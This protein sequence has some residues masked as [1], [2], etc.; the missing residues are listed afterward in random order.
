[1]RLTRPKM[2]AVAAVALVLFTPTA[3][4]AQEPASGANGSRASWVAAWTGAPQG[5]YPAGY[6]IGQPG[7]EGPAGPGHTAP[8]LTDAFPDNQAH[9]QTLRMIVHPSMKAPP[10]ACG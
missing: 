4:V 10:G 2:A 1:M 5:T 8:L 3:A 7:P 9:N 6:S